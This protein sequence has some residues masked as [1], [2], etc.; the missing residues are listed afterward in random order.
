MNDTPDANG[1]SISDLANAYLKMR[2]IEEQSVHNTILEGPSGRRLRIFARRLDAGGSLHMRA[3][4]AAN[5]SELLWNWPDE[6]RLV[7]RLTGRFGE[8]SVSSIL[9]DDIRQ[10]ISQN[11]GNDH[12]IWP[13]RAREVAFQ[14]FNLAVVLGWLDSNPAVGL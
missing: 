12:E 11:S 2:M 5:D 13:G 4:N 10:V 3:G 14:M 7:L 6:R 9:H 1:P 8:K